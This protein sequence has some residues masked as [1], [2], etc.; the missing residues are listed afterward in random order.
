M[1]A[2]LENFQKVAPRLASL[3]GDGPVALRVMRAFSPLIVFDLHFRDQAVA[4]AVDDLGLTRSAFRRAVSDLQE[5]LGALARDQDLDRASEKDD[6]EDKEVTKAKLETARE[7]FDVPDLRKRWWVKA[8]TKNDLLMESG[9]DVSLKLLDEAERPPENQP[10]A[11]GLLGLKG[12][13]FAGPLSIF[14]SATHDLTVTVDRE[15][16]KAMRE[17]LRRLDEALAEAAESGDSE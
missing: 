15:D 7:H 3:V 13:K 9:W 16:I 11:V 4:D 17:T 1:P 5:V 8:N 12:S 6:P 14:D 10:V 2:T